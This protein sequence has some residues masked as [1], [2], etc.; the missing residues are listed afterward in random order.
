MQPLTFTLRNAT[1]YRIDMRQFTPDR[2]DNKTIAEIQSLSVYLGNRK[3]SAGELFD[4]TGN[5]TRRLRFCSDS[6]KLDYIGAMMHDGEIIVEGNAGIS[7]GQQLRGGKLHVM[8]NTGIYAGA[9][10]AAG[11]LVIEGNA[12]DYIGAATPGE[13]QGMTGGEIIVRGDCG[14]R[15][16]DRQRRGIIIVHGGVGDYCGS[17]MIAGTIAVA[18]PCGKHAGFNMKRGTLLM[19]R[20]PESIPATFADNGRHSLPFMTLLLHEL[21]A[22]SD[23]AIFGSQPSPAVQRYLGDRACSGLGEIL[24]M[25]AD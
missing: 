4:I 6:D 13:K 12:D 16:G 2:L 14:D 17:R 9:D 8:G 23:D 25:S 10:M 15:A 24:V 1:P 22:L 18:G 21:H 5:D 7:T 20:E 11:R 19:Q 3:Y